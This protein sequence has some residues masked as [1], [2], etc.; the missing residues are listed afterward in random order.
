[1]RKTS[2]RPWCVGAL[3]GLGL[4]ITAT[5]A[6]SEPL[7]SRGDVEATTGFQV[8]TLVTGLEH[9]WGL[10]WLPDG[11]MLITEKTG[12][13]RLVRDGEL[14][15][16]PVTGVPEVLIAGQGGTLLVSIGD[17]GNPPVELDGELIRLEP[18]G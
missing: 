1:M 14:L 17:G 15:T 5:S 13:L 9:P 16:A 12:Q 8:T 18:A 4:S 6:L 2:R 3:A 11:S 7:I 10:A